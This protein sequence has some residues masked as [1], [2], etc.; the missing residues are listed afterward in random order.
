[1]RSVLTDAYVKKVCLKEM[2]VRKPK[3]YR[4][5]MKKA[6]LGNFVST[7]PYENSLM[8]YN[9][10]FNPVNNLSDVDSQYTLSGNTP[11]LDEYIPRTPQTPQISPSGSTFGASNPV[12]SGGRQLTYPTRGSELQM[13][14]RDQ[15]QNPGQS[16]TFSNFMVPANEG[17]MRTTVNNTPS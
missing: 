16:S 10:Q 9:R 17:F 15:Q 5:M 2:G 1:M 13:L 3:T 14:L 12:M 11:R 4:D 7:V 6:V 8:Y